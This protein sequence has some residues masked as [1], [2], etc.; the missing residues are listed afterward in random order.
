MPRIEPYDAFLIEMLQ[1]EGRAVA[2]LK[3]ALSEPDP[4]VFLI[5][6]RNVAQAHGGIG[7]IAMRSGLNRET[8]YRT[9]SKDGNP[10]LQ[11]LGALLGAMGIR[12]SVEG[13]QS[14]AARKRGARGSRG[15][16]RNVI[17]ANVQR[18]G[19]GRASGRG[20]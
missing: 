7:K 5:A 8:L 16:L 18:A 3:A 17:A 13:M 14:G 2:Y 4:R 10:S 15:T 19:T 11:S 20:R 12:L 6:L 9:L 1:D